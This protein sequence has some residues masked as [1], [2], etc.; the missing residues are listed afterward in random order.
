MREARMM[1]SW[2]LALFLAAMLLWIADLSLF[3][4]PEKNI[5]FPRLVEESGIYLWEPTGRYV[6]GLA[7]VLAALLLVIPWTRRIGAILAFLVAAGAVAMHLLWLGVAIPTNTTSKTT[8]GGQLFYLAVALAV[9]SLILA[10]I[11]PG[12]EGSAKKAGG[13][14]YYGQ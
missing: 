14:G 7:H 8:D 12:R 11:H 2:V 4:P 13:T 3:G 1:A 9:A 10:V 5:V 6:V